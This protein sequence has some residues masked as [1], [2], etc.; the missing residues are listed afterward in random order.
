MTQSDEFEMSQ[1]F[2]PFTNLTDTLTDQRWTVL[3][4]FSL[5]RIISHRVVRGSCIGRQAVWQRRPFLGQH[6]AGVRS[7]DS[8]AE[9][10]CVTDSD[11][12]GR[13]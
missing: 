10:R 12:D 11:T 8:R 3:R 5:Y 9:C 6:A 13:S 1:Q 7:C 2:S 4:Y